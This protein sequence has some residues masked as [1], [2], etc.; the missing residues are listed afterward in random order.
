MLYFSK[1]VKR[2]VTKMGFKAPKKVYSFR[3]PEDT[4]EQIK[5]M[6]GYDKCSEAELIEYAVNEI[7][8]K[9]YHKK[10]P[11]KFPQIKQKRLMI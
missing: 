6:C 9:K 3:L 2:E 11:D 4:G 7:Y 8:V 1:L 10:M 5:L